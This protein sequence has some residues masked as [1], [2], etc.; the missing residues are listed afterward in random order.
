[1]LESLD[2]I[3][4]EEDFEHAIAEDEQ[5]CSR[6]NPAACPDESCI[7]ETTDGSALGRQADQRP[8]VGEE[9]RRGMSWRAISELAP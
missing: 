9:Q 6:G 4:F 3:A 2:A 7:F 5:A 1:M 8:V